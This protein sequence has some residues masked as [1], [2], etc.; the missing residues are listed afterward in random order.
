MRATRMVF[1]V[2]GWL[3]LIGGL[4]MAGAGLIDT[5]NSGLLIGLVGGGLSLVI[6]G[7]VFLFAARYL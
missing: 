7:V 3:M 1:I 4:A 2:L 5:S 6:T